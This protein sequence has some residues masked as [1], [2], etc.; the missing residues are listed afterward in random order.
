MTE[1]NPHFLPR[2]LKIVVVITKASFQSIKLWNDFMSVHD[3]RVE[4]HKSHLSIQGNLFNYAESSPSEFFS[5][6]AFR[7]ETDL[8][9]R[10]I[11]KSSS[12]EDL[13]QLLLRLFQ[14]FD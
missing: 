8:I 5:D 3:T 12:L 2:Q 1:N 7:R 6:L 9:S 13:L 4:R 10:F 14:T 11:R